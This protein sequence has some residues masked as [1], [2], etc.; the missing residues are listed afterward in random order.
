MTKST[1]IKII[2]IIKKKRD[3]RKVESKGIETHASV[4]IITHRK[5]AYLH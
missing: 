3:Q 5:L 2:I 4:Q 1:T